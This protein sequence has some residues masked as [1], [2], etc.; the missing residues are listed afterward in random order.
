MKKLLSSLLALS[1][2]LSLALVPASALEL[3]QAKELLADL[4]VDG[5]SDEILALDSLDAILEAIGDPYTFY[6]TP[7]QYTAFNQSVNGQTVVGIGATAELAYDGGYRILS[8]LPNSPALEAGIQPGDI[9]VAVDGVAAAPEVPPQNLIAGEAGTPLTLTLNRGGQTLELR[10]VRRAVEIPIVTYEL[11]GSAGYIDCISFGDSTAASVQEAV[12]A[13]NDHASV[14]IMDLR[15]NPGGDSGATA[16]SASLFVGQGD[17][18]YFRDG[19]GRH[20]RDPAPRYT[21]QTDKPVIILTSEH[22]AS[23]SE[24]FSGD[25]RAYSGGIALG[26]RTF[27]KGTAQLVLNAINCQYMVG[28]EAMKITAYRFFAPDGATNHIV[29]ILP[30][31][32][33]SPENTEAA[34][35]LL[36][37]APSSHPENHLKID[38]AGQTFYVNLS[39]ALKE[40]N[41]PALTELLEALP[42]SA[43]LRYSTGQN[44]DDCPAIAPAALAHHLVIPFTART[45]SDAEDSEYAWEIDTLTTYGLLSGYDDGLFHPADT[46]TRAQF[47][48]MAA[49][50]LD[51]PDGK[52]GQFPDVKEGAWYAGAVSAMADMGF[53]SGY[54][55]GNFGPGDTITYQEM[56]SILNKVAIWASMDGYYLGQD[57]LTLQDALTYSDYSSWAQAA[58]RNLDQLESLLEDVSPKDPGTREVAAA[59]LCRLMQNIHLIWG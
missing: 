21:D 47:C 50:A 43:Q 22:S 11:K 4:Y 19:S 39:E 34:A 58:A 17:M 28:G 6:M 36:S 49:A 32:L 18:L 55:N 48:A 41:R 59:T 29:G 31:L 53:I 2:T 3:D 25:I 15:S 30:T 13:M 38:L 44:W 37:C 5:V 27:G 35:L 23:G 42:P 16:D 45:L 9:I 26:Q 56:V 24:L 51:L 8:V 1:L 10:L 54:A 7:E 14:W 46:V 20:Y 33:I 57:A 52:P 12:T 40:E